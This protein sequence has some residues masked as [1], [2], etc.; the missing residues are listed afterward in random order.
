MNRTEN[1]TR[2]IDRFCSFP[3]FVE[4]LR[5]NQRKGSST[6]Q[7]KA[8]NF[9]G[10]V[11]LTQ[12]YEL[13]EFG[14][15]DGLERMQDRFDDLEANLLQYQQKETAYR[16]AVTGLY[17]DPSL[18]FQ[19]IPECC[20]MPEETST[21]S[22]V[23]IVFNC[24]KSCNVEHYQIENLG[25]AIYSLISALQSQGANVNLTV[26]ESVKDIRNG[27]TD[28]V[29]SL[30]SMIDI[31]CSILDR[32]QLAFVL[33]H[34]AFLRQLMFVHTEI[35]YNRDQPDGYGIPEEIK[36]LDCIKALEPD[37]VIDSR[38]TAK[39]MRQFN[40]IESSTEWVK[41]RLDALTA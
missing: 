2:T 26:V 16:P 30:T 17:C 24:S 10:N 21:L 22:A 9:N 15:L 6:A 11:T 39:G 3:E 40:T 5:E 19:G 27:K 31:D 14:W 23:N 32:D 1:K 38:P 25:I 28:R 36:D 34:P 20:F 7:G 4:Y 18:L 8:C 13:A 35:A 12:A 41:E 29:H 33:A 37:L